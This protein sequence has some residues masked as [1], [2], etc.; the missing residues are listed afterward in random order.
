MRKKLSRYS[1]VIIALT[2]LFGIFSPVKVYAIGIE[3]IPE[4]PKAGLTEETEEPVFLTE[5]DL[6][7]LNESEQSLRVYANAEYDYWLN[8][9]SDYYYE[10]LD[11]QEKNVWDLL[12]NACVNYLLSD[13]SEEYV[14]QEVGLVFPEEQDPDNIFD[15]MFMFRYAHPQFYFLENRVGYSYTY[16]GDKYVYFPH[17]RVFDKFQDGTVREAVTDEFTDKVDR[18]VTE[19]Q[20]GTR[21][22]AKE[23]IAYDLICNN[24]EYG[25][26]DY[27]QSAYSMV[28]LGETVCAGYAATLQMVLNAAGVDAIEVTGSNH[29]WNLANIHGIWYEIDATWGDQDSWIEYTYY[30]KSR[31]TFEGYGGHYIEDY[32]EEYHPKAPYDSLDKYSPY[33]D[34]Y[35]ENG[36]YT[37]FIINSNDE[38][39]D[40]LAGA[41][42]AKNGAYFADAPK[43]VQSADGIVYKTVSLMD[44]EVVP[45]EDVVLDTFYNTPS[46]V[47][48]NWQAVNGA[49]S[50]RV[51]RKG[52]QGTW[53]L[54]SRDVTGTAYID[55]TAVNGQ[56]YYYTVRAVSGNRIS[57]GYDET[58]KI[59]CI[60]ALKDVTMQTFYNTAVGPRI[61]WDAVGDAKRYRVYRRTEQSD[62]KLLASS[63]TGTQY[64]DKTAEPYTTYYY[65]VRAVNG[66]VISAG[67]DAEKKIKCVKSLQNVALGKYTNTSDGVQITWTGVGD[68]KRYRVYRK[69]K[70]REWVMLN[71]SVTG[72]SYLDKTA[73][74]DT[75]YY[76]TVRAVNGEVISPGYDSSRWIM[77]RR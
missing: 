25:A 1:A 73:Q 10:Q 27:D 9:S 4:E 36:N 11:D 5:Q 33:R 58:K 46:G 39:G 67:Y 62:W 51:Y 12:E 18:W 26:N 6:L 47:E 15:F 50:Y 76:Y 28:C 41:V 19:I 20:K 55:K 22:E 31:E 37:Y 60:K 21:P 63:V 29:A 61:M 69:V 24:T 16:I 14:R 48:V 23:K 64:V 77:C 74:T 30:N 49:T 75:I 52:N 70:G 45:L 54:L 8:F 59:K 72:T 44:D 56:S 68:A 40:L 13:S 42:E 38:R 53:Q 3:S 66:N 32:W 17:I 71:N 57:P 43:T 2:L 35:F 65:T 34:A 7:Q